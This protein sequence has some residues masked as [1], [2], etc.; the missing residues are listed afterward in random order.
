[1][2]DPGR[3]TS[4]LTRLSSEDG[5][6]LDSMLAAR[7]GAEARYVDSEVASDVDSDSETAFHD[8]EA[9][10][11]GDA[12]TR[13]RQQVSAVLG[14]LKQCPADSPPPDLL[15]RTLGRV[16]EAE[17]RKRFASQIATL[18]PPTTAFRLGDLLS[19]A[20]AVLIAAAV[21]LPVLSRNEADAHR[22]ACASHQATTGRA[23][24]G[25]AAAN[26]QQ[27]PR[28]PV[29]PNS[30]WYLVGANSIDSEGNFRSNSAHIRLLVRQR[31]VHPNTLNCPGNENAPFDTSADAS[32]FGSFKEISFSTLNMYSPKGIRIDR[33]PGMALLSD[34]N[35]QFAIQLFSNGTIKLSR[36]QLNP[37]APS[38]QHGGT[39]QNILMASGS[40]HWSIKPTVPNVVDGSR[41][42]NIFLME[43]IEK[44]QGTEAPADAASDTMHI[45]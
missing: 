25:Y 32:D 42:D 23:L 37:D 30:A 22:I 39:G 24:A 41:Q 29:R 14:L 26:Q 43:G 3:Q 4:K 40:V 19:V 7:C 45:P 15:Q 8:A 21:A 38:D 11:A 31:F 16:R 44:Y 33:S 13:R 36:R 18:S 10:R 12:D 2:A 1:M 5:Q 20:A 9:E 34:K 6:I 17:Q 28:G 35:P 27:L